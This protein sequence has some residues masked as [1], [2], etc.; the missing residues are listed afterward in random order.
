MQQHQQFVQQSTMMAFNPHPSNVTSDLI[1]QYLDENKQLILAI[2]ESQS[3]GKVDE[4]AA[5][6]AKLQR[7]LMYLAAVADS[8]PHAPTLPQPF[9][10]STM[11]Q[12]S[13]R[14]MQHSQ[15]PMQSM[16]ESL[17]MGRSPMLYA[18][19]SSMSPYQHQHALHGQMGMGSGG[20]NG[21]HMMF[22]DAGMA[23]GGPLAAAGFA[24]FGRARSTTTKPEMPGSADG[25]GGSS[26]MHGG[27]G[28]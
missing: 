13:G 16:P 21:L 19:S 9:P 3:S 7:N 6:Q 14:F 12:A 1:Q 26:G 2:M 5:N 11:G 23:G 17:M 22:G 25:R 18:Q 28:N 10:S 4:C 20:S 24:D 8:Q 27:D 15:E